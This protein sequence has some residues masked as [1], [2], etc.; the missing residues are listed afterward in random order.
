MLVPEAGHLALRAAYES[1]LRGYRDG[2]PAGVAAWLRYAAE[3][4]AKGAEASP[5]GDW[6]RPHM[7]RHSSSIEGECRH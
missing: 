7:W 6:V 3:A 5:L 2:G 4:A 1:N